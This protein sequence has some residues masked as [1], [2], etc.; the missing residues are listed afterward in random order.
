MERKYKARRRDEREDSTVRRPALVGGC[1]LAVFLVGLAHDSK[2][3]GRTP[4]ADVNAGPATNLA[5]SASLLRQEEQ[6]SLR[7]NIAAS[8]IS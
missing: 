8:S 4:V 2:R 7:L 5:T 6:A 3:L 1:R